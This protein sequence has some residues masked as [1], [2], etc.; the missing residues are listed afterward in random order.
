MCIRESVAQFDVLLRIQL[1]CIACIAKS[2]CASLVD[3]PS[4][5]KVGLGDGMIGGDESA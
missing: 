4:L 1:F 5:G 3:E 2:E